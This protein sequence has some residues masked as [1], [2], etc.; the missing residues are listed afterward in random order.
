MWHPVPDDQ[1]KSALQWCCKLLKLSEWVPHMI[2]STSLGACEGFVNLSCA[3]VCV[4]NMLQTVSRQSSLQTSAFSN[5]RIVV[6]SEN[7][8]IWD[9]HGVS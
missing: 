9:L 6:D 1:P 8:S 4:N 3:K 2:D 5:K 7:E